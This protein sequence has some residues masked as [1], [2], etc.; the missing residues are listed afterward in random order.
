VLLWARV[1]AMAMVM[2]KEMLDPSV[3]AFHF[4]RRQ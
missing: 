3:A 4:E 2:A 1:R